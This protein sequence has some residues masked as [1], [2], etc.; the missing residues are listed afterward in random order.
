MVKSTVQKHVTIPP[1][2]YVEKDAFKDLSWALDNPE[3]SD[4]QLEVE[5]K[6]IHAHRAILYSRSSTF[7]QL[8][9]TEWLGKSR[10]R[11]ED[12]QYKV[13]KDLLQCLYTGELVLAKLDRVVTVN[14]FKSPVVELGEDMFRAFERF[15]VDPVADE[16]KLFQKSEASFKST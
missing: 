2:V 1:I 8:L 10:V 4:I 7:R 13:M 3:L 12:I 9:T 11:V 15:V 14:V 5:D 16:I 6:V